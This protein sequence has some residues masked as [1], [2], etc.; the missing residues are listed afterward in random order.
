MLSARPLGLSLARHVRTAV[1]TFTQARCRSN[2]V[3]RDPMTGEFTALPD[4]E[5]L[6]QPSIG[7][8]ATLTA[9]SPKVSRLQIVKTDKP[10]PPPAADSLVFGRTFVRILL[11][12]SPTEHNGVR[13]R[14]IIC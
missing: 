11:L 6:S 5:V 14:P 4:I 12:N 2:D 8:Y 10:R 3:S 7:T 9:T 13:I 1:P